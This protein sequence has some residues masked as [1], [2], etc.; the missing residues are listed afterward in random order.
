MARARTKQELLDFGEKEFIRLMEMVGSLRE[1]NLEEPFVFDN[2]AVKDIIAHLHAWHQLFFGWYQVGMRGEKPA[3]PAEGYSFKDTPAL[4]EKLFQEYKDLS[5][6]EI[7]TMFKDSHARIMQIIDG[8]TD[9]ELITK[10]KYKWTGSTN[11]ASYLAS[12]TSSHY[13]W[14][15]TMI[16]KWIRKLP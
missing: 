5:A 15:S 8:H 3:I 1:E 4:N 10:K 7:M 2:R 13:V 14:A 12:A 11:L 9:E 16:R 6:D